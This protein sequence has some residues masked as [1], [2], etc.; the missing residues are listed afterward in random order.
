[1][2]SAISVNRDTRVSGEMKCIMGPHMSRPPLNSGTSS[3][4]SFVKLSF[5]KIIAKTLEK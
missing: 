2:N 4:E 1:M 5:G 3:R